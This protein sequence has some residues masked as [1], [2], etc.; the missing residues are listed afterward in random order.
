MADRHWVGGTGSWDG[1]PG[2]KWS[3]TSGGLGGQAVP[4]AA[5][6]VYI[7]SGSG[8]V[9]VTVGNARV[10]K[11]LKFISGSGSFAGTFAG[12]AGVTTSGDL[13]LS[14][15]MTFTYTGLLTFNSATAQTI[16]SNGKSIDCS[17]TFNGLGSFTLQDAL[18]ITGV[19]RTVTLT[20]GALDLNNNNLTTGRFAC[21]ASTATR[22]VVFGTGEIYLTGNAATILS[23]GNSNLTATGSKNI[24]ATFS[25][26]TG[27]RTFSMNSVGAVETNVPNILIT[28]GTD[29]VSSLARVRTLDFTGFEGTYNSAVAKAIFGGLIFDPDMTITGSASAHNLSA[30]TGP[31]MIRTAG[32]VMDFPISVA[33]T[34]IGGIFEFDDALTMGAGRK[35]AA[36]AG[37]IKFKAGTTNTSGEFVFVGTSAVGRQVTIGSTTLG[38]QYTLSQPSGT[39]TAQF[40]TISDSNATGGATWDAYTTQGNIDAGNNDGWDFSIQIGRYI[41]TRRKNKRIL[42]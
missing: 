18:T 5:D 35:F 6:D 2:T 3:L 42:P 39:V 1:T 21:S 27:T 40:T 30:T 38:S 29:T 15:A 10:C 8:A 36:N 37:T 41:Y 23:W 12:S 9:T 17:I 33:G 25:G 11:S 24:F 20:S 34:A 13:V 7:D 19:T 31:F 28:A 32:L 4:T 26:G 14:A 22:S 16:T